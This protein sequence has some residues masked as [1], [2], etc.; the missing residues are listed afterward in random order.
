MFNF[1][2]PKDLKDLQ[3][4]SND[5]SSTFQGSLKEISK[6]VRGIG[7]NLQ[8]MTQKALHLVNETIGTGGIGNELSKLPPEY[9]LL[10]K[11]VDTLKGVYKRFLEVTQ[12]YE[13]ESY[14]YPPNIKE[15]LS[16]FSKTFTEKFLELSTASTTKEAERI[17]AKPS[18]N[19]MP[20]TL[21]HAIAK[22]AATSREALLKQD[23]DEEDSFVKVLLKLAETQKTI[24]NKRLE[25]DSLVISQFNHK[26][27]EMLDKM[28]KETMHQRKQVEQSRYRLDHILYESRIAKEETERLVAEKADTTE[29]D[30]YVKDLALKVEAAEDDLVNNTTVAVQSMQRFLSPVES[31]GL[32]KI[33]TT[34]QLNYFKAAASDLEALL[35]DIDEIAEEEGDDEDEDEDEEAEELPEK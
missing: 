24:G 3:K 31:I 6:D 22:A 12:T 13:I 10:E 1:Q 35:K 34:I 9:L 8:P 19:A 5:L 11:K 14:D 23:D 29:H 27:T 20:K 28:F 17:L 26:I 30:K 25:Q 7:E 15:S 4:L 16:D 32:V 33:L 2:L 21:A 18:G